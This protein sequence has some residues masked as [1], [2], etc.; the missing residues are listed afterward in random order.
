[1]SSCKPRRVPFRAGHPLV[2]LLCVTLTLSNVTSPRGAVRPQGQFGGDA[3]TLVS[4]AVRNSRAQYLRYREYTYKVRTVTRERKDDGKVKEESSVAEMIFPNLKVFRPKRPT[5]SWVIIERNGKPLPPERLS[6]ERLKLGKRL[7][8][9]EREQE[10][11]V[12]DSD[13]L[14][15]ITLSACAR[16]R[17]V[18]VF[19][20]SMLA[21]CD[22]SEPRRA[23]LGGRETI[24]IAFRPR[25][26]AVF[27]EGYETAYRAE[28]MLWIDVADRVIARVTV[29]PQGTSGE[30]DGS[31]RRA[32]ASRDWVRTREGAWLP[33]YN[34]FN[35]LD[36][37]ELFPGVGL[38]YTSEIFDYQH[39]NVSV[40][41]ER[42]NPPKQKP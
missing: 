15:L 1:V 11:A 24:E 26:G 37:P 2:I 35:A 29:W 4:E 23:T 25:P 39:F 31:T 9:A 34:H 3:H 42:L 20:E 40:E 17:C 28:G 6:K 19:G 33:R 41:E 22:F 14:D 10:E 38:E 18:K 7:E 12:P 16:G 5:F 36:Y 30:G 27:P 8:R 21:G 32:A 13:R